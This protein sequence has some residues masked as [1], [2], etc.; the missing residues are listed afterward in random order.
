MDVAI[1]LSMKILMQNGNIYHETMWVV[2]SVYIYMH[3]LTGVSK[4]W[5]HL[6]CTGCFR[7]IYVEAIQN[8]ISNI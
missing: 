3:T 1:F 7:T 8:S 2:H 5:Y 6:E 4:F